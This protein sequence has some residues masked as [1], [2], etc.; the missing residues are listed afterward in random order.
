[1][2]VQIFESATTHRVEPV[3]S[4]S[5]GL[6]PAPTRTEMRRS[7]TVYTDLHRAGGGCANVTPGG[8]HHDSTVN[9]SSPLSAL[10]NVAVLSHPAA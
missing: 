1:M 9:A 4:C 7:A 8:T 3:T 2:H 5:G 10:S 6:C